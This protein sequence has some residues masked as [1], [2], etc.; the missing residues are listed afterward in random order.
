MLI[1]KKKI[2]QK[3]SLGLI[4]NDYWKV[5]FENHISDGRIGTNYRIDAPIGENTI[6]Y[7]FFRNYPVDRWNSKDNFHRIMIGSWDEIRNKEL[8][9]LIGR[10]I[11]IAPAFVFGIYFFFVFLISKGNYIW[12]SLSLFTLS[13]ITLGPMSPHY[14]FLKIMPSLSSPN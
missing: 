2:Y 10:I 8:R 13:I 3:N 14:N 1:E 7:S 5:G 6:I 12:I 9:N 4:E 11:F